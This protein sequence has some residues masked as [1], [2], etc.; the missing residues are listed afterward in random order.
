[1]FQ[2]SLKK[3]AKILKKKLWKKNSIL[4]TGNSVDTGRAADE[5]T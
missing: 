5:T 4:N 3:N 1:M 2:I